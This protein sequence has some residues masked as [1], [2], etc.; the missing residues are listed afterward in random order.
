MENL[1][2]YRILDSLP[3]DEYDSLTAMAAYI[4][5]APISLISLVDE[6]RQWFK[7]QRGLDPDLRQTDRDLAFCSHTI[8]TPQQP[9]IVPDA[10]KDKRFAANEFVKGDPQIVFY[11]GVPLVT[12]EGHAL[13]SLCV[14]DREPRVLTEEQLS[15]LEGLASQVVKLF[16]LRRLLAEAEERLREREA[17]YS[18]LRDFSHVIA[19]DLKAP[20]RNIQQAGEILREEYRDALPPDGWTLVDMITERAAAASSMIEGVLRYSQV[21]RSLTSDRTQ[22][23]VQEIVELAI[24]QL[25]TRE[26]CECVL[27][28]NLRELYTSRVALLQ[29]FQNLIGN[30]HKFCEKAVCRIEIDCGQEAGRGCR[31]SVTDNGPGIPKHDLKA[32]FRLFHSARQSGPAGHGVGLSIVKRLVEA[33]GGTIEVKSEMGAGSTFTFYLPDNSSAPTSNLQTR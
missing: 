14:I 10:R 16:E 22:V 32:I 11:A 8:L 23:N 21:S 12:R 5:G 4:C 2:S 24:R 1:R 7:S 15:A 28:G 30:A 13:G 3:E 33:L 25:G 19:H 6:N 17:A 18:L 27:T 29:I 20:V 26:R 9:M 31:F